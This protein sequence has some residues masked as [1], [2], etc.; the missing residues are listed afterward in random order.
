MRAKLVV[1][2]LVGTFLATPAI[3]KPSE[4]EFVDAITKAKI[5]S[6]EYRINIVAETNQATL[7]TFL[8][9]ASNRADDDCKINAVLLAK[10]LMDI[11]ADLVK[12]KVL[13]YDI[14]GDHFRQ[15]I[16]KAGD[17]LA[18]GGGQIDK[19]KLLSSL[20]ITRGTRNQEKGTA[21]TQ[22]ATPPTTPAPNST[23]ASSA[24]TGTSKT[25]APV[26]PTASAPPAVPTFSAAGISFTYPRD[27]IPKRGSNATVLAHFFSSTLSDKNYIDVDAFSD[28]RSVEGLA[29]EKYRDW[30]YQ[31]N[32]QVVYSGPL[33]LG[34]KGT[35]AGISRLI[36]Y[37]IENYPEYSYYQRHVFFGQPG[38]IYCLRYHAEYKDMQKVNAA[39]EHMLVTLQAQGLK[40]VASSASTGGK[41]RK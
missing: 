5:L 15:I 35:I 13:F 2:S 20:E 12:V 33:K 6:G 3:A 34:A 32:Y 23:T 41:K 4:A 24:T 21:G 40:P 18:L 28:N 16:V 25:T 30:L 31:P 38:R 36:T 14:D 8:D 19:D 1:T 17:V 9:K 10:K 11:D 29:D 37:Q 39:F 26:T 7:S 22:T 27:W